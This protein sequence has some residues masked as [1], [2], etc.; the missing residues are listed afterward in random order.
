MV[1]MGG[2]G[3]R[4]PL[5]STVAISLAGMPSYGLEPNVMIS[6]TVTPADHR[7]LEQT[8]HSVKPPSHNNRRIKQHEFKEG[9]FL[10]RILMIMIIFICMYIK[11]RNI[12]WGPNGESVS[13]HLEPE[14]FF[15]QM[16]R[17]GQSCQTE[18]YEEIT[19]MLTG[20]MT[21]EST[22]GVYGRPLVSGHT[23]DNSMLMVSILIFPFEVK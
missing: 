1:Q 14:P 15:C 8:Q 16:P 23:Q 9:L 17:R 7:L 18:I 19:L 12:F 20:S 11:D 22:L 4:S 3:S 5:P 21:S 13:K 2:W 10:M 6:H